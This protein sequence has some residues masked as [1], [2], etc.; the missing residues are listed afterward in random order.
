MFAS[1]LRRLLV[2]DLSKKWSK[3]R[4]RYRPL[5][6][7][8]EDRLV[9]AFLAPTSYATGTNPAG[10][11]VGDFNGDGKSDMAVASQV[12]AGSVGVMLSNGDGTFAPRVDYSA[13]AY[14]SDATAADFNGDGRLDLAVAGITGS[15]AVLFGAGDGTFSPPTNWSVGNGAHSIGVGDF[16]HDGSLDIATMNS[17]SASVVFNAGDGT[18]SSSV[19]I[20]LPGNTTNLVVRDFDRDGNLDLATSNTVSTGTVT[21][22]KGHG[23]STFDVPAS[24]Y[25]FS[26][27]VSLSVGDFNHDGYDDIAVANSYAAS[28]MSVIMNKGDGT[29]APPRTYTIAQT[30]YEIEV[31]DFNHDGNDD[32]AVRGGSLYMVSLGKGD[33]T[34]YPTA[35]FST[36]SGR[37][38]AGTHGDFN[39]DGAVDFAYPSSAGVTVVMN[40][41]DDFANVAGAVTFHVDAP[42]SSTSGS[43]LPMTVS[44]VDAAG[45]VVTGFRGTVY[46]TSNDPGST[47]SIAY[48]F[49]SADAGVHSFGGTVKL[50]TQGNQTVTVAAP[51]LT[52]V[53]ATVNVTPAVSHFSVI[54]PATAGAGDTIDVTVTARDPL[55]NVGVGYSSTI[56]FTSTDVLA[57][58]PADYTFTQA[59]AGV[60]TFQVTVKSSGSRLIS[61]SEIGGAINGSASLVVSPGQATSYSLAGSAGAVGVARSIVIAARDAFGNLAT[62]DQSVVHVT[63]SDAAAALPADVTLV[64]GTATTTVTLYTVGTQSITATNVADPNIAGTMLSDATPPVASQFVISG[65][66]ATTAGEAGSLTITVRDTIGQIASG[67]V[68]TV[69]FSSTDSQAT[70]PTAYT[71]TAA[72]AGVRTFT[73]TLR[74]AGT[75]TISVVD[76]T[77]TLHGSQAGV[78]VSPAP[79]A[80]FRLS[81]PLG[82]DSKGHYLVTAGDNIALSVRAVDAFGNSANGYTGTV[83]FSSTDPLAN[84][85]ADYLFTAADAGSHTFNVALKT[86]TPK[87]VVWNFAVADAAN[88][89][90]LATLTNFE[91]IN[92]A[93][94]QFAINVPSRIDAG[95]PFTL[96]VNA[97]DAFGNSA[98]NYFGTI[99]FSNTAGSADLPADYTFTSDDSGD[100]RFNVTLN[101]GGTQILTVS[102]TSNLPLSNSITVT[103]RGGATSSAPMITGVTPVFGP[104]V[105]GTLVIITGTNFISGASVIFGLTSATNVI[106]NSATQ[107]TA[108]SPA[109]SGVVDITVVTS[110]GTSATSAADR[111]T[112]RNAPTLVSTTLNGGES[113]LPPAYA[114]QHS[115]IRNV[116]LTFDFPVALT[117]AAVALGIHANPLVTNP[118]LP[119]SITVKNSTGGTR[120]DKVWFVTFG[121]SNVSGG[122]IGNGEY[123]LTIDPNLVTDEFGQHL[124]ASPATFTFYRLLGDSDGNRTVNNLDIINIRRCFSTTSADPNYAWMFDSDWNGTVNTTDI[125]N[126]RRGSNST[127]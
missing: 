113:Q 2:Q 35:N 126:L 77:G 36:P 66:T 108:V 19:Q 12:A 39:G 124:A 51:F 9:P 121:G 14:A 105:G 18:F 88:P 104:T 73:A 5:A 13:A 81:V 117:S 118:T 34:F 70:L 17:S 60:H 55:G 100:H 48:T 50:V 11:A 56:H 83:K 61:V 123:D 97:Y 3:S 43:A 106:V 69:Y 23:D 28:S 8:L 114:N 41:D 62:N 1:L 79:F 6:E 96:K 46:I 82:T 24:Y 33:G 42:A 101:V 52:P 65:F 94:S 99:H 72:D 31:E 4:N 21:I 49:T 87:N 7:I 30:G 40:A 25:A 116:Q 38:E 22:I 27:P 120:L 95:V 98:K 59:D 119:G 92:A 103:V 91:V 93:A 109:G 64:N 37:F 45:N 122:S 15:V 29:Y 63:S 89:A 84:L 47:S 74:T 127:I 10:I 58:L 54:A 20:V 32:Y 115:M 80:S 111:F 67:F 112:Y 107:I 68:G 85:P 75:Q 76:S 57:G 44:A 90:T 110:A 16:N 86:A 26:A 78:A 53:N 102:D 71:F 125:V